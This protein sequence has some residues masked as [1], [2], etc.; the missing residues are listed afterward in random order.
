M[1]FE[2]YSRIKNGTL[3]LCASASVHKCTHTGLGKDSVLPGSAGS[4]GRARLRKR[5][6]TGRAPRRNSQLLEA[7]VIQGLRGPHKSRRKIKSNGLKTYYVQ[8]VMRENT[9]EG[10]LNWWKSL[11][12]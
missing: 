12:H 11:R 6:L 3:R 2:M 8:D 1:L 10:P 4:S 5:I 9:R 7:G